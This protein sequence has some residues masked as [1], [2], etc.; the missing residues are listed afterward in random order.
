MKHDA[1]LRNLFD[2]LPV[3]LPNELVTILAQN[4]HIRFERI[5]SNGHTCPDGFWYDQDEHEWVVV[6]N[7]EARLDFED[8]ESLHM[9]LGDHVLIP[10]H[11]RH[12][13]E[14]TTSNEPTVWLAIFYR[15]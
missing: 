14:W 1:Q 10:P 11:R 15:N 6:L 12:R 3:T 7:G 8:G 13:V 5:V 9:K 4:Q 2:D